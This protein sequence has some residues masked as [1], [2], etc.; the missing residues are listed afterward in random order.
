[1]VLACVDF[2]DATDRVVD[3]A[4]VLASALGGTMH[5]LHVAAGEPVLAGYDKDELSSFTRDDRA[6]Q[7][8]DE[9]EHLRRL[10]APLEARGI[11]VVP[12]LVMGPTAQKILDES[13]RL[14]A[15]FVVL[16]SHGHRGLHHLLVGDVAEA[17]LH[18]ASMPVVVVPARPR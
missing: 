10:A 14:D 18:K 17:V 9:R 1:M 8:V 3:R 6:G 4:A 2:S 15:A 7:L 13:E 5:L 12:L 11:T 16:G